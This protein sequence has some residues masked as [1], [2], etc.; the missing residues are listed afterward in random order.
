MAGRTVPVRGEALL[1][2]Q[3]MKGKRMRRSLPQREAFVQAHGAWAACCCC[4][5]FVHLASRKQIDRYRMH[6]TCLLCEGC[7]LASGA[8]DG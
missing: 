6:A 2:G 1:E 4:G 3:E 8:A 7:R 5:E